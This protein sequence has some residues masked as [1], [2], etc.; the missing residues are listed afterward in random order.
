MIEFL[1]IFFFGRGDVQMAD[2]LSAMAVG[3]IIVLLKEERKPLEK[4]KHVLIEN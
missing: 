2:P 4:K 1:E 3:S